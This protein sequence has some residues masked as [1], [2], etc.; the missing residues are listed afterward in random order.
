MIGRASRNKNGLVV[1]Y[2]RNKKSSEAMRLAIQ[3]TDRRRKKQMA[4]NKKHKIT[5]KT[6]TKALPKD[7]LREME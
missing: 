7:F 4:Y 5:P 3:E 1:M 2:A 6:I